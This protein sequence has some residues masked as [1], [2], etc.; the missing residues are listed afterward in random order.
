MVEYSW[1]RSDR[2]HDVMGCVEKLQQAHASRVAS[3]PQGCE[4]LAMRVQARNLMLKKVSQRSAIT[5]HT[6]ETCENHRHEVGVAI[7]KFGGTVR[8]K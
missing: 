6:H 4:V 7:T 3:V 8:A 5:Q 1:E 2:A